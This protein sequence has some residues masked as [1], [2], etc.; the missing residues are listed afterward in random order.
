MRIPMTSL[1]NNAFPL[2]TSPHLHQ[3]N[4]SFANPFDPRRT[5]T[6][7]KRVRLRRS[8]RDFGF[9]LTFRCIFVRL[10]SMQPTN[11]NDSNDQKTYELA[12]HLNPNLEEAMI[13]KNTQEL[14]QLISQYGGYVVSAQKPE[15]THLSYPIKHLHYAYF[16][17]FYFTLTPDKLEK[18]NAH[19]KLDNNIVRYM[20]INKNIQESQ[21][22]PRIE[23]VAMRSPAK[24]HAPKAEQQA[25]QQQMEQELENVLENIDI[26]K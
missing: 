21:R 22:A 4:P 14:E 5:A 7:L 16:G 10:Q 25:T 2:N 23:D 9:G 3:L 6:S 8:V 19:I 15:K 26:K 17:T 20:I 11:T 1:V 24:T 13:A 18:I 12:Y